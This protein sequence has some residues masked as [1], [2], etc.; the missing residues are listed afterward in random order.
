MSKKLEEEFNNLVEEINNLFEQGCKEFESKNGLSLSN[1]N[2]GNSLSF[3]MFIGIISGSIAGA[4]ASLG[5]GALS[6]GAAAGAFGGPVGIAIGFTVGLAITFG[7]LISHFV[8]KSK[9]YKEG[10]EKFEKELINNLNESEKNMINDFDIYKDKFFKDFNMSLQNLKF[11]V[12][13]VDEN[14]WAEIKNNYE[15][16]KEKNMKRISSIKE[17]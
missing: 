2:T 11:N 4:A 9:K 15:I 3:K 16:E 1:V 12:D 5:F 8:S 14:K 6:A 10:V 13:H 17:N 7:T